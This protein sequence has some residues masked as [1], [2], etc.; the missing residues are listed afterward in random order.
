MPNKGGRVRQVVHPQVPGRGDAVLPHEF[1]HVQ[2]DE[3]QGDVSMQVGT[4]ENC[5]VFQP[6]KKSGHVCDKFDP[7]GPEPGKKPKKEKAR[8]SGCW[9]NFYNTDGKK[10]SILG[11]GCMSYPNATIVLK[12]WPFK[13]NHAPPWQVRWQMSCYQREWK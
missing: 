13:T 8:C 10:Q 4:C 5:K 11:K 7:Y 6:C 2:F 1:H 12:S 9:N 3:E